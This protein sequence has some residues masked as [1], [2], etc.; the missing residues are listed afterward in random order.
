MSNEAGPMSNKQK[1]A[2]GQLESLKQDIEKLKS[3]ADEPD[4]RSPSKIKLNLASQYDSFVSSLGLKPNELEF[5]VHTQGPIGLPHLYGAKDKDLLT[6]LESIGAWGGKAQL[7][8]LLQ[9]RRSSAVKNTKKLEK[10]ITNNWAAR[11]HPINEQQ[12]LV[13]HILNTIL[14]NPVYRSLTWEDSTDSLSK[15]WSYGPVAALLRTSQLWTDCKESERLQDFIIDYDEEVFWPGILIEDKGH[16]PKE[17]KG[18]LG[19][20]LNATLQIAQHW[21][22]LNEKQRNGVLLGA[23]AGAS[24]F[25]SS[26]VFI[27]FAA[28]HTELR[29]R[30]RMNGDMLAASLCSQ[31]GTGQMSL[32]VTQL[33]IN[34][35]GLANLLGIE[36]PAG[37]YNYGIGE[38]ALAGLINC[39]VNF[40]EAQAIAVV[41]TNAIIDSKEVILNNFIEHMEKCIS[42]NGLQS[43]CETSVLKLRGEFQRLFSQCNEHRG[44]SQLEIDVIILY[45]QAILNLLEK[46]E[47]KEL[48]STY[49]EQQQSAR[50]TGTVSHSINKLKKK[51]INAANALDTDQVIQI[52]SE[53]EFEKASL[54]VAFDDYLEDLF[55]EQTVLQKV[56]EITEK[57]NDR[58]QYLIKTYNAEQPVTQTEAAQKKL[59]DQLSIK[60]AQCQA[61]EAELANTKAELHNKKNRST[62][63]EH[64]QVSDREQML[65]ENNPIY[66]SLKE[67]AKLVDVLEA[68]PALFPNRVYVLPSAIANARKSTYK[69]VRKVVNNLLSLCGPYYDA[70]AS[71]Q[72]DATARKIIGTVYRAQESESTLANPRM[73]KLRE[74]DVD[75]ETVLFTQ[76]LTLG[77]RR[78]EQTCIQV[79][80]RIIENK[81]IIAYVGKHLPISS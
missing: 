59:Q 33:L 30:L 19:G 24:F 57:D 65:S 13:K 38:M 52:T 44:K 22:D 55:I 56:E 58:I 76:H 39:V 40:D 81:L 49:I 2:F 15:Y 69:N 67:D 37:K 18:A 73:H 45:Q 53:I 79:Y 70:L 60:D 21:C 43:E 48:L 71:G 62:S 7:K 41:H 4:L 80:F 5:Y 75:G 66:R 77:I 12:V 20:F 64:N 26:H 17:L 51:L 35:A 32:L 50:T 34:N 61:L 3:L 1:D 8:T 54:L 74:F 28:I 25:Q 47:S 78:N 29:S 46:V 23:W 9:S 31:D 42:A 6:W 36:I 14:F 72:S 63:M 68:L 11:H 27:P 10:I 16:L